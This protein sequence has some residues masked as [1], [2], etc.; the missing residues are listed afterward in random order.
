MK[1]QRQPPLQKRAR[2]R[3]VRTRTHEEEKPQL[4]KPAKRWQVWAA[5]LTTLTIVGSAVGGA[6]ISFSNTPSSP[7][8]QAQAPINLNAPVHNPAVPQ[9][10]TGLQSGQFTNLNPLA[11]AQPA[12]VQNPPSFQNL[13]SAEPPPPPK[14]PPPPVDDLG[15]IQSGAYHPAADTPPKGEAWWPEGVSCNACHFTIAQLDEFMRAWSSP[16]IDNQVIFDHNTNRARQMTI[17]D[18][19]E[20]YDDWVLNNGSGYQPDYAQSPNRTIM[21]RGLFSP[22]ITW[23]GLSTSAIGYHWQD[24]EGTSWLR[25]TSTD[26][27]LTVSNGVEGPSAVSNEFL[28]LN[29]GLPAEVCSLDLDKMVSDERKLVAVRLFPSPTGTVVRLDVPSCVEAIAFIAGHQLSWP[30]QPLRD[31][32]GYFTFTKDQADVE[33]LLRLNAVRDF[34]NSSSSAH[35]LWGQWVKVPVRWDG[36][37][38]VRLSSV[39]IAADYPGHFAVAYVLVKQ[40]EQKFV[41]FD[42][43][44]E[45]R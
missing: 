32:T 19:K 7:P 1:A 3:S 16:L 24:G 11:P 39:P 2:V 13:Q 42:M 22:E 33:K 34:L 44:L 27:E 18:F 9:G 43:N 6:V 26:S 25:V 35:V 36:E 40:S 37:S 28:A 8:A 20:I 4:Q 31:K 29:A 12:P 30:S 23:K 15:P 14:E 41:S 10:S 5:A 45:R 21:I 38:T 17:G